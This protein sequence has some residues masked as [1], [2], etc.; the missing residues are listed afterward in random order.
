M[1][2][3]VPPN[4][5]RHL[6]ACMVCSIVQTQSVRAVL[7]MLAPLFPRTQRRTLGRCTVYR[8]ND[9][10]P[11]RFVRDGCPNCEPFL[12]LINH[13]DSVQECTSQ[14]F[15][16]LIT[17]NEPTTSWVA[18]WQRLDGYVAGIYA[19]KVSGVVSGF[20]VAPQMP[21]RALSG[22]SKSPGRKIGAAADFQTQ[23]H[24]DRPWK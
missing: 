12:D 1:T 6:R 8:L 23:K 2:S 7:T 11:Q 4:Q 16:G 3:Y 14:V 20:R 22:K 18:K 19:V 13:P 9:C 24:V 17:L 15:E 21:H 10:S 5:Q